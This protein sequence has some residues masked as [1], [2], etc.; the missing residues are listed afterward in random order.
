VTGVPVP[1][2]APVHI[3]ISVLVLVLYAGFSSAATFT[4]DM[5][6]PP[7]LSK[8]DGPP[9][10]IETSPVKLG[11]AWT[12]RLYQMAVSRANPDRCGFRPSC[13]AFAS[14][15]IEDYGAVMGIMMTA[16]RLMRCNI[17]KKPG[18][19]YLL[20]PDGKL[21]DPPW[22]NLLMERPVH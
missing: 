22:R 2:F 11:L 18:P 6:G 14:M 1:R 19:D 4:S 16:D 20:L 10:M 15:S 5:R 13:S 21:L 3:L 8:P 17:W 7:P 12:I 9:R